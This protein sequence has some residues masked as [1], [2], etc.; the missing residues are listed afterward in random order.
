MEKERRTVATGQRQ[1][2]WESCSGEVRLDNE[3][4]ARTYTEEAQSDFRLDFILRLYAESN[5]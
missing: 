1:A 4:Y 2:V 5:K 3:A